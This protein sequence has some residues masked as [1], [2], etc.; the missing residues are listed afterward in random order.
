MVPSTA[1]QKLELPELR[2]PHSSASLRPIPV[3]SR[4]ELARGSSCDRVVLFEQQKSS[5]LSVFLPKEGTNVAMIFFTEAHA[6][7]AYL[8]LLQPCAP[9]WINQEYAGLQ[10]R[11][12]SLPG[13]LRET[14][15]Q[16]TTTAGL[17]FR[18]DSRQPR[19]LFLVASDQVTS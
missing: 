3:N 11:R 2:S 19:T 10:D 6:R 12:I 8:S 15:F 9:K 18:K 14:A 13:D 4:T 17:P 1:T 5:K 7:S 16:N